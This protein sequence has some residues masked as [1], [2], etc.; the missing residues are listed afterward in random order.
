MLC[1]ETVNSV[2]EA[3]K[4]ICESSTEIDMVTNSTSF[5]KI[6]EL[7]DIEKLD[8]IHLSRHCIKD[9]DNNQLF[10][11][12]TE[13]AFNIA[14]VLNTLED[15][16][17]I[18]LNCVLQKTG[19]SSTEDVID[20][21]EFASSLGIRNVCFIGMSRLNEYCETNYADPAEINFTQEKGF[22][23]W[24]AYRDHDFCSCSSGSYD[25]EKGSIRFYYRRIGENSA[26][27]SRQLVYTAD[28]QLL[29]GFSGTEIR[30]EEE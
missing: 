23:I 13:S 19:I 14:A 18:V 20:Y 7:I 5:T 9:E 26:P 16:A 22:H 6:H 24:N 3:V 1:C 15:L 4:E 17:M 10:G 25:A 28:N 12:Q 21:L 27:Y 11:F 8:S 30:F 29:A 2:I